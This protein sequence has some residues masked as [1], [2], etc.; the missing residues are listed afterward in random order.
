MFCFPEVEEIHLETPPLAEV[1]CQVRFPI[2]LRITRETPVEFQER[3]RD[4]FPEIKVEHEMSLRLSDQDPSQFDAKPFAP[5]FRF[6]TEDGQTAASLAANFYALSTESYTHWEAFSELLEKVHCAACEVYDLAYATRV[7]LRYVNRFKPSNTGI[8][9]V[10]AFLDLLRPELTALLRTDCWPAPVEMMNRVALAEDQG[11]R[12][13]LGTGFQAATK[14]GSVFLLDLDAYV[15]DRTSLEQVPT[16]IASFHDLIYRAF[17]WSV[18]EKV[19]EL[20]ARENI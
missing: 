16:V 15:E 10:E 17:R 7:G 19:L 20:G 18:T 5:V 13:T 11:R 1:I 3:I 12:L 6:R 4:V 14:E 8:E 2:V 9:S